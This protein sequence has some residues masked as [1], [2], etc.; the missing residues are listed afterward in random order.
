MSFSLGM[1]FNNL[2]IIIGNEEMDEQDKLA[3]LTEIINEQ[4]EYAKDCGKFN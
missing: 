2:L 1:F 3:L 4:Y